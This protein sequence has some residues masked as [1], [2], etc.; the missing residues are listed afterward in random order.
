ML[1]TIGDARAY[2]LALSEDREWLDHWKAAYRLLVI[3]ASAAELTQQVHLALSFDGELDDI[4]RVKI[5]RVRG[6]TCTR[7]MLDALIDR[8]DRNVTGPRQ[9]AIAV[10][11]LQRPQNPRVAVRVGHYPVYKIRSG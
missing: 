10:D 8:Q 3:G 1:R 4:L 6:E 2:M 7:R 5:H 9:P 11:R